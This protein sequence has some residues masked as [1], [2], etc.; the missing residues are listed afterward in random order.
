MAF[1]IEWVFEHGA[2][3][4]DEGHLIGRT[5]RQKTRAARHSTSSPS[6]DSPILSFQFISSFHCLRSKSVLSICT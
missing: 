1:Q 4:L 2:L 6:Q 3:A 5:E